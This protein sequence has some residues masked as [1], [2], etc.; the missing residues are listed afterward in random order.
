MEIAE[1][2]SLKKTFK[3]SRTLLGKK[4]PL[5]A[6]KI[7][8]AQPGGAPRIERFA[9]PLFNFMQVP[10]VGEH[11]VIVKGPS[12]LKNPGTLAGVYYYI[13]PVAVHGN[14]HLNPMPGA[15]D[16]TK[17]GGGA[18]GMAMSAGPAIAAKFTYKPGTNFKEKKTIQ[19]LQPYEG[20]VL[21]EGRNGQALRLGSSMLGMTMHY[22]K[23]PF[24]KGR[25]GAPI[26]ILSNGH[27]KGPPSSILTPATYGIEDPDD[28]DSIFIMSSDSHKI[29]MKLAKAS[30]KYGDGVEKLSIYLKPQIILSS[31]R[32]I[33]N[34]KK[35]EILLIAKKDVKVVTK[36]WH[37]DMDSFFTQ[38]LD[39]MEEVIKQNKELEKAFKEIGAVAQSNASSTHPTA[40]GPSG[41]PLNMASFIKSKVKATAGATKTKTLRTKLT[42]IKNNVKKMKG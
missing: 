41:P 34:S 17:S 35:D 23:Q 6:V 7:R 42:K 36:K 5:G 27:K 16:V 26:T 13:G 9:Y 15:F 10:L 25:Q 14:K 21:I 37:T 20:D 28:V 24:Y 33:L 11:I 18:G 30:R 22:A 19:S 3:P 8:M 2:V 38:V 31:D 4:L 12:D 29:S 32:I 1:V 39:F 40:V